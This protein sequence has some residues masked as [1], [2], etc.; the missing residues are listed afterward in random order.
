MP[1]RPPPSSRPGAG[2]NGGRAGAESPSA[3]ASSRNRPGRAPAP[4]ADED[5][6]APLS[7]EEGYPDDGPPNPE[8]YGDGDEEGLDY[9]T[10]ETRVGAMEEAEQERSEPVEEDDNPDSTRA[11]PP[12]QLVVLNGPDRG[13]KKRFRSVRM[14]VGRGKDCDFILEDQTV[15]RRHL[16]LVYGD[17]GVVMRDLGS[18]SGTQINDERMDECTLK[19]GDEISVGKT[20]LRFVDEVEQVKELRAQAEA[21]EAEEKKEREEAERE[22]AEAK[23]AA[24]AAR[25]SEV[26]PSDPRLTEATNARYK[27]EEGKGKG[28]VAV[29]RGRTPAQGSWA[30]QNPKLLIGL[31]GGLVV[32]VVV[33]LM[34]RPKGPPPPPPVDPRVEQARALMQKARKSALAE[35]LISVVRQVEEAEKLV[36]GIDTEGLGKTAKKE[37]A[38]LDSL[39]AV[40]ALMEEQKFDEARAK[41]ASTE[42]GSARTDELR[43][44]LKGELDEMEEASYVEKVKEALAQRV[45]ED[46]RPLLDKL[47]ASNRQTYEEQL[48]ALEDELAKESADDA[49]RDRLARERAAQAAKEKRQAFIEEAFVEVERRFNGRDYQRAALECD[50]VVE[51]YRGDKDI[52][53][54]AVTIKKLI[55]LFK[56]AMEDADKKKALQSLEAAVK[57]L[58]TASDLYRRIGF[59]GP[60]GEQIDEDLAA[61]SVVAGK[62]ALRRNDLAAAALN[63]RQAMR[64]SPGS[65]EARDGMDTLQGRVREL[66]REAAIQRDRD[67]QAAAVKLKVVIEAAVEGSEEQRKAEMYLG[68]LQQ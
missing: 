60:L 27:M 65:G 9:R 24:A 53:D 5:F 6:A 55:P 17:G 63:F 33:G 56:S 54:R 47:S 15:S 50:R 49:R 12:V 59:R 38:V 58:K 10:G 43:R 52:S 14:V 11:G 64:L 48:E 39:Q 16:E 2:R 19:H 62:A 46:V 30:K 29:S 23:K 61:A 37:Q 28:A 42:Q 68:E 32:L 57:P 45:P 40:R 1:S 18:V 25:G 26:D 67:P 66:L 36:P 4:A 31:A 20:R 13:R 3:K 41:L 34:L 44:K 21:R 35:D 22:A 7:G 51:K 8:L